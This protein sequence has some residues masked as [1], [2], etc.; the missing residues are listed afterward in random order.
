MDIETPVYSRVLH[1]LV[2]YFQDKF[3]FISGRIASRSPSLLIVLM[4]SHTRSDARIVQLVLTK[5]L[6][7]IWSPLSLFMYRTR[8]QFGYSIA[9][10]SIYNTS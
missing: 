10:P 4:S 7:Y 1:E 6:K 3:A 8:P 2:T 9:S 5:F